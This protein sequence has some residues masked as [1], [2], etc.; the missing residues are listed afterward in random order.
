MTATGK[1]R[2][3][4]PPIHKEQKEEEE[5]EEGG[6]NLTVVYALSPFPPLLCLSQSRL[7]SLSAPGDTALLS[8]PTFL[9]LRREV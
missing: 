2:P 4:Q 9:C 1:R 8:L 6:G 5:E 7:C 3:Q